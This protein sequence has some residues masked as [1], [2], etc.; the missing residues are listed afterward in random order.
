M[1]RIRNTIYNFAADYNRNIFLF[2]K[3]W[4]LKSLIDLG[5]ITV[6]SMIGVDNQFYISSDYNAGLIHTSS[7]L[8]ILHTYGVAGYYSQIAHDS[9]NKTII[10]GNSYLRTIEIFDTNLVLLRSIKTQAFM[11]FGIAVY[12]SKIF[13]SSYYNGYIEVFKN[14]KSISYQS[15]VCS[16]LYA[17]SLDIYGYLIVSCFIDSKL[18]LYD[19]NGNYQNKSIE[20]PGKPFYVTYDSQGRITVA[21]QTKLAVYSL[22]SKYVTNTKTSTSVL[23]TTSTTLTK[24]TTSTTTTS[25]I[26]TS[27]L[28]STIT[29]TTITPTLLASTVLSTSILVTSTVLSTSILVS[30][31]VLSTS[32]LVSSTILSTSILVSS[33]P[34]IVNV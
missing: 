17:I 6:I 21:A 29:I 28:T 2:D 34:S 32:I 9:K 25:I 33:T 12:D 24:K 18:Y 30:S 31:T 22:N 7:N 11:N 5:S 15:T 26:T 1:I 10:A 3:D 14:E 19:V 27:L 4:N 8:T 23:I 16:H 13:T 20:L